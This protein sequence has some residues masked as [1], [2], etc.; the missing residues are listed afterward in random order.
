VKNMAHHENGSNKQHQHHH[1]IIPN[2]VVFLTGGALLCLT[3]VTV[4]VAHI[5]LGRLNFVIAMAVATAKALMVALIFMNLWYDKKENGIIFATSFLFLAIFM[6]LTST[7][8]FFRGDVYV[9]GPLGGGVAQ[10]KSKLKDPWISTPQL[11][12][13]GKELFQQQC[14]ACH[15]AEGQGN[16]PAASALNP[17]PR[18]FTATTGWKNGRKV[19]M[20]FKTLKEGIPGSAMA[21]FATLASDDRWALDHYVLS[22]NSTA[23]EASTPDDFKKAG[24][25]IMGGGGEAEEKTIP[26]EL[27]ISRMSVPETQGDSHLYRGALAAG[28]EENAGARVYNAQC[29]QCHGANGEG[30]IKVKNLGVW[31]PAFATTQAFT[32]SNLGSA[33][34]FNKIVIH[35]LPGELMP[36]N[37]QLSGAELR[38]LYQFTRSLKGAR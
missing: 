20:V 5:D 6:V 23:P 26:L 8:V 12:A 34:A 33:E 38:D 30:G 2:K 1:H 10:A 37:G 21:S 32:P 14:V 25:D 18:N 7:D 36:G 35:G 15:G 3:A 22:L 31:P 11:V 27:A 9:K 29:V 13:H 4:W 28:G 24:V 17:P 16:G 19:A